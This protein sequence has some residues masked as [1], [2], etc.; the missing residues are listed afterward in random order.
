MLDLDSN[1]V[2]ADKP[3]INSSLFLN[4]PEQNLT[5]WR[6]KPSFSAHKGCLPR[7]NFPNQGEVALRAGKFSA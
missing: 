3:A 6:L 1:H 7:I 4:W 2:Q 5:G